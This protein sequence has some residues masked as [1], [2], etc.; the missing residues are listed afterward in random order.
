[1]TGSSRMPS[2]RMTRDLEIYARGTQMEN[3]NGG[4]DNIHGNG[5]STFEIWSSM[6][7]SEVIVKDRQKDFGG[8]WTD[9]RRLRF[10][11]EGFYL[12]AF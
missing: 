9:G 5:S 4:D 10:W 8:G 1:M 6:N 11:I 2:D 3:I 12:K 7:E